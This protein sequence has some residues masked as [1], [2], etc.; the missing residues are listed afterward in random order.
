MKII[1]WRCRFSSTW[2]RKVRE[3]NEKRRRMKN[4]P[5]DTKMIALVRS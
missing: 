2:T 1:N 3:R 4:V 5:K